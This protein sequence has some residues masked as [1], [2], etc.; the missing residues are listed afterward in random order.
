MFMYIYYSIF[1]FECKYGSLL[2]LMCETGENHKVRKC[3]GICASKLIRKRHTDMN[4]D[5]PAYL[6]Y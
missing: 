6:M 2:F 3:E 1:N 5:M 4:A